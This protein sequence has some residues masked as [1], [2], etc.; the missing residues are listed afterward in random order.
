MPR[1]RTVLLVDDSPVARHLVA[2]R[3]R[4]EGFELEEASS[5]GGARRLGTQAMGNLVGAVLD[6]ELGD[7]TGLELASWLRAERPSLPI[8]FFTAAESALV[9][10]ARA[11]GPV[12]AKV[13]AEP[14]VSWVRSLAAAQPPPTK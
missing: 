10:D 8:A 9:E 11:L 5:V 13:D 2:K 12:F 4:A 14:L 1:T 6:L 7:G 3:L